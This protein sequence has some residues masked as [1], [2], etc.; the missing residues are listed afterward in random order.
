MGV[1]DCGMEDLVVSIHAVDALQCALYENIY[2]TIV[3][4]ALRLA[5]IHNNINLYIIMNNNFTL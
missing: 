4:N 2:T 3:V 1:V 5:L